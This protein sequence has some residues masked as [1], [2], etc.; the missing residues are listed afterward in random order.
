M[1][2]AGSI[3]YVNGWRKLV[4]LTA[5]K[6]SAQPGVGCG[7]AV[8]VGLGVGTAP[9]W[10]L[11]PKTRQLNGT[12]YYPSSVTDNQAAWS[13][14]GVYSFFNTTYNLWL[15]SVH[16]AKHTRDPRA[17]GRLAA[18]ALLLF[19]VPAV[20]GHFLRSA[21]TGD[22]GDELEDWQGLMLALLGENL[23]YMAGTMI[24]T[25]E[26]AGIFQGYAGYEGPAGAR[27]FSTA[28]DLAKQ[29]S[30]LDADKDYYGLDEPFFRALNA[31]GG[32]YFHYPASQVDKT[33]RGILALVN[34]ETSNPAAI[35]FGPG[36]KKQP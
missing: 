31:A 4:L 6:R 12:Y 30:Q 19:V 35:L 25:R 13:G 24:G 11:G 8:G 33:V 5:G 2:L 32:V 1:P 16:E 26:L 27:A 21:L 36:R 17:I 22:L 15:D 29:V 9:T 14:G 28:G 23:A 20:L 34:G 3:A 7:V 18:D 10:L